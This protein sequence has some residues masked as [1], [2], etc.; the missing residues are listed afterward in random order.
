M[1]RSLS[2]R[3]LAALLCLAFTSPVTLFAR[4]AICDAADALDPDVEVSASPRE[5]FNAEYLPGR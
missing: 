2:A 1:R 4:P 5:S 3:S